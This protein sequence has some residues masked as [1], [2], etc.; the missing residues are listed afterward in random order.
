MDSATTE[1]A[2]FEEDQRNLNQADTKDG[3]PTETVFLS[4]PTG[5]LGNEVLRVLL[6]RG[7]NVKILVRDPSKLSPIFL[8]RWKEL[9]GTI[10]EIVQGDLA[11]N[12]GATKGRIFSGMRDCTVVYHCAGVPEGWQVDEGIW[13]AVNR[14]GTEVMLEAAAAANVRMFVHISALETITVSG[15]PG[16]PE[17]KCKLDCSDSDL[18]PYQRSKISAENAVE[19]AR[20]KAKG[21]QCVTINAASFYGPTTRS[22]WVNHFILSMLCGRATK[23]RPPPPPPRAPYPR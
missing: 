20:T 22:C 18:T 16:S 6:E 12:D 17:E 5:T 9:P 21:M 14:N 11:L 3:Q 1:K 7:F 2:G 13:D 10:Q 23:A 19:L 4:G 8:K 15:G